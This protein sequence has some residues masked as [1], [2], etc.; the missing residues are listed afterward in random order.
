MNRSKKLI[1]ALCSLVLILNFAVCTFAAENNLTV[2]NECEHS[3]KVVQYSGINVIYEC[4]Y[5]E[6]VIIISKQEL[7]VKWNIEYINKEPCA[8]NNSKYLDINNDSIIN[9]K[10]YAIIRH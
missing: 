2:P 5:C 4:A 10:D 9:A 8:D 6:D 1:T 7:L 3:C